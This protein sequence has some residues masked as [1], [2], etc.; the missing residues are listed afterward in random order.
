MSLSAFNVKAQKTLPDLIDEGVRNY[1]G[2]KAS[3]AEKESA[4]R[5]VSAAKSEYIPK[6]TAQHQYTYGTSNNVA[7]AFYP[8]GAVIS[9]SGSIR[10]GNI[11]TAA[12]GSYTSAIFEWNVFNFGKVSANVDASKRT[13]EAADYNYENELLQHKVRIADAYLQTLMYEKLAEIQSVNLQRA[14][15]FSSVVN[16][17][18]ASG[19]RAGVDSS[20]ASAEFAKAKLLL[21]QA[22]R[23]RKVKTLQ[24]QELTGLLSAPEM[25]IDNMS[26]LSVLPA[27]PDISVSNTQSHP[28]IRFYH[29]R[30]DASRA[31]SIAT[32][33]S[34]LPSISLVGAAWARGSGI[35]PEDDSYHTGFRDGTKYQVQNYLLGISTR[36]I[37]SDLFVTRHRYK[38]ESYRA[39]RD[40][41]L[42]KEGEARTRREL[43]ES[44][45]QYEVSLEQAHMAPVQLKA[46][47]DAYRQASARYESGLSDLP[48]LMQSM[49]TLNRAEADMAIAYINVWRSLLAIAALKGDFSIFMNAVR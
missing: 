10:P 14:E 44:Q 49:V 6:V 8:N 18:V 46:A 2:I 3:L 37:I 13:S 42:L 35:Y 45:M 38:S 41:A 28:L 48:T 4:L 24:L 19:M 16:A 20:L 27:T 22:Q 32:K 21:L 12:W 33:R 15:T 39:L 34:Y 40:D 9:P 29:L 1:P 31:R 30:A 47:R 23:E 5:D 11:N 26:F 43:N 17:G 25:D 36:W 7:G